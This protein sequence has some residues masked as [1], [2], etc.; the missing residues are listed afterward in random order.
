M[1]RV[2]EGA[3]D[4]SLDAVE[5]ANDRFAVGFSWSDREGARHHWA[6]V[7]TLRD[8]QIVDMQDHS[9]LDGARRSLVRNR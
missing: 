5:Q 3:K 8:E 9:T 2:A 4:Y 7:L 1:G 6:H